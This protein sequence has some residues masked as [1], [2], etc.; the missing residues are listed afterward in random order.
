MFCYFDKDNCNEP[1]NSFIIC[2]TDT[3]KDIGKT[4]YYDHPEDYM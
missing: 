1:D 2:I 3:L 4:V